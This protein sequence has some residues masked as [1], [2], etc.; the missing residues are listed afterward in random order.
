MI[1]ILFFE[2]LKMFIAVYLLRKITM[3]DVFFLGRFRI[4]NDFVLFEKIKL[5]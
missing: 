4:S 2:K 5:R 3:L 1:S